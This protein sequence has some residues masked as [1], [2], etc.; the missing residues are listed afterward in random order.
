MDEILAKYTA[1]DFDYDCYVDFYK[2][3]LKYADIPFGDYRYS[4]LEEIYE[5]VNNKK[6]Y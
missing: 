5:L 6:N 1:L 3:V 2:H 4:L